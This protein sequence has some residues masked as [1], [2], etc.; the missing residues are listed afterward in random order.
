[1]VG[2]EGV[3]HE[4]RDYKKLSE[5]IVNEYLAENNPAFKSVPLPAVST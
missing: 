4:A 2:E 1:M 3:E 5:V